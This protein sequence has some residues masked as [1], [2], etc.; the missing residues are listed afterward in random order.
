MGACL[1]AEKEAG[2]ADG[3]P[4]HSP[5]AKARD[6]GAERKGAA[7][8]R[9]AANA[10]KGA[11]YEDDDDDDGS[12][13]DAED[14]VDKDPNFTAHEQGKCPKCKEDMAKAESTMYQLTGSW[15]PQCFTCP[16]CEKNM[17]RSH[18][19]V[20]SGFP[21]CQEC[22]NE[23]HGPKCPVCE[24]ALGK[25]R[26][27]ALDLEWHKECFLCDVCKNPLK[28]Q[29]H[30]ENNKLYCNRDYVD[31]FKPRCGGCEKPLDGPFVMALDLKFHPKCFTC[32]TCKNV[33]VEFEEVNG[34][35][36]CEMCDP[37]RSEFACAICTLPL[38]AKDYLKNLWGEMYCPE[39]DHMF[40]ECSSC[41]TMVCQLPEDDERP[42]CKHCKT[43]L[44]DAKN[45]GKESREVL[46]DNVLADL[47]KV[48]LV[49]ETLPR[50]SIVKQEVVNQ[51][52]SK[53]HR[54]KTSCL[55]YD[56]TGKPVEL[57]LVEGRV[58]EDLEADI[59]HE[60]GHLYLWEQ[61]FPPLKGIVEEGVSE[62]FRVK[63][64]ELQLDEE[65][66]TTGFGGPSMRTDAIERKK[67]VETN[68]DLMYG[69]GY[70]GL[71]DGMKAER[72]NFTHALE[73]IKETKWFPR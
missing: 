55:R 46:L 30:Y 53:A 21:W 32:A 28:G 72:V 29:I 3:K 6:A 14:A 41:G 49:V 56:K 27:N 10:G 23:E 9:A 48:G 43:N 57:F 70:R 54:N 66:A 19:V 22:Y 42:M 51:H 52:A 40:P 18:Y 24:K 50:I 13:D 5:R 17:N 64:L 4:Q 71:V 63:F 68:T 36:Y 37:K 31:A 16:K 33:L 12:G 26:V 34:E 7:A 25:E 47:E 65:E 2:A 59:A 1:S 62:M 69:G 44:A 11:G 38:N 15:H 60:I 73:I 8:V 35:A 20:M 58:P 45:I 39:H 67:R 61:N